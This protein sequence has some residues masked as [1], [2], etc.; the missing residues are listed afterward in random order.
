MK[1]VRLKIIGRG[2]RSGILDVL[3]CAAQNSCNWYSCWT[4]VTTRAG[5]FSRNMAKSLQGKDNTRETTG[6]HFLCACIWGSKY[7]SWSITNTLQ[8]EKTCF[9]ATESHLVLYLKDLTKWVTKCI[10]SEQI[11]LC[12]SDINTEYGPVRISL[13]ELHYHYKT[14]GNIFITPYWGKCF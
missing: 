11:N 3:I 13:R 9:V 5:F 1:K 8:T 12:K 7:S 6:V 2:G 14:S 10:F 4:S